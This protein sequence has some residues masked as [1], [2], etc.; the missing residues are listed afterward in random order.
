MAGALQRNKW[1][2]VKQTF[3]H[4]KTIESCSLSEDVSPELCIR[5]LNTPSFKNFSGFKLKLNDSSKD[6]LEDFVNRDGMYVLFNVLERLGEQ[7]HTSFIDALLQLE[8]VNCIKAVLNSKPGLD[9]ITENLK[10]T[11]HLVQGRKVIKHD[12]H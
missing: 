7:K 11:C 8:C 2:V 3:T 4:D 10:L 6:W 9:S 12:K 5:L 1:R